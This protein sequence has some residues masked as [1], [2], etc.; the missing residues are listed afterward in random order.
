MQGEREAVEF[1]F[2]DVFER[3][4]AVQGGGDAVGPGAQFGFVVGVV[5]R[6]HGA[7]VWDLGEAVLW[8]AAD[9]L[10][11]AVGC[12]EVRV[13]GFK[14]LQAVDELVVLRVG[15]DG[16]VEHVI[17]VLVVLDFLAQD[18]DRVCGGTL[19]GHSADCKWRGR[20]E[21]CRLRVH[22]RMLQAWNP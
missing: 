8:L 21:F 13:L 12:D 16:C 3:V 10:G 11:G 1:V 7:G 5:E 22:K 18:L 15:E 2:A 4:G 6:E 14:G 19:L 17:E 9:A 20:A